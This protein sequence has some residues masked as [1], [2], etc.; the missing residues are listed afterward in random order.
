MTRS[1]SPEG[2]IPS[3]TIEDI[4]DFLHNSAAVYMQDLIYFVDVEIEQTLA[5]IELFYDDHVDFHGLW[6]H[7]SGRKCFFYSNVTIEKR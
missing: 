4:F 3:P 1:F 7:W 5:Y 6:K 2:D